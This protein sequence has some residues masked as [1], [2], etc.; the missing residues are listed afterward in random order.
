MLSDIE[1]LNNA[2]RKAFGFLGN[3]DLDAADRIMR[4]AHLFVH[5]KGELHFKLHINWLKLG[6]RARSFS[7]ILKQVFPVLFA[8]P[9]S[10]F[11]RRFNWVIAHHKSEY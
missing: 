6:W 7:I 8:I 10:F 3:R 5:R 9:V 2:I 1:H 4:R 11:H